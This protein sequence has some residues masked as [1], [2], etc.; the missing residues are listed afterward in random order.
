MASERPEVF[1]QAVQDATHRVLARM[2]PRCLEDFMVIEDLVTAVRQRER[3]LMATSLMD[4]L[5]TPEAT[6][7]VHPDQTIRVHWMRRMEATDGQ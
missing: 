3:V 1:D 4:L 5:T 2:G 6:N 7:V